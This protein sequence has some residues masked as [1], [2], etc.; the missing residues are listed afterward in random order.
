MGMQP[1]ASTGQPATA[2]L[3]EH[4][5]W[6]VPGVVVLVIGLI[7][8][9][10]GHQGQDAGDGPGLV[11]GQRCRGRLPG[12]GGGLHAHGRSPPVDVPDHIYLS[13]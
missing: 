4:K 11:L 3:A 2:P 7:A 5:A 13:Y 1:P 8:L 9:C 10:A 12:D 6:S